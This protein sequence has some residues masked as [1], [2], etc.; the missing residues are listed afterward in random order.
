MFGWEFPPFHSGGLGTACYGLTKA[1][2]KKNIDVIFVMPR[3]PDVSKA[4]FVKII[5]ADDLS[6]IKIWD[7]VSPLSAYMTQEEYYRKILSFGKGGS[8]GMYS[9]N[10]FEEVYKYALKAKAIAAKEEHDVIH[11]HDWLT[12]KAGIE[13][14]KVSS[15]P[16]VVHVHATEFDRTGGNNLNQSVYDIERE[17]MHAADKIIA[18]SEF[19]KRKIVE[20]YD[21]SS[22]KV[23]V[24]HNAV[25]F[26]QEEAQNEE[27]FGIKKHDKIVLFLGRITIQKGPDYFLYAA[28]KIL[29]YDENVRFIIAGSG[30]MQPFIIEKSAELGIS[31]KVLFA[32]FLRG[33]DIDRAYKMADVYVMP[34]VSE[35]FGI[36]P[37][38][39]MRNNTPVIISKQ[40]GVSEVIK[41]CLKVDFWDVDELANKIISVLKYNNLKEA[42]KEN[43]YSEVKKF[44][45]M[46]PA[47]KCIDVYA[48][49]GGSQW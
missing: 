3:A 22:D 26:D 31:D 10:L 19:T 18:V 27:D 21:I 43:A 33:K 2:S 35:P 36:T 45:W 46:E 15:K 28:K 6:R 42:L 29:D 11:A 24:V 16:L 44:S 8:S 47:E 41:H 7:I 5:S 48:K 17:G 30:D 32:G 34:S 40:S 25:E 13:A 4:E 20:H 23:V 9:Q 38:E 37:L 1:L 12:F 14:K 49:A 39:A